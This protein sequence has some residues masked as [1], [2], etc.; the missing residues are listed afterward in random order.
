MN[1]ELT[2]NGFRRRMRWLWVC[3]IAMDILGCVLYILNFL[4][5]QEEDWKLTNVLFVV[6]YHLKIY[7]FPDDKEMNATG[8]EGR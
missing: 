3:W 2:E 6:F 7:G 1:V 4:N 5:L 8:N